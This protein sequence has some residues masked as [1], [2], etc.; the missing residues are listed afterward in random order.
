MNW[1]KKAQGTIRL[2]LDDE[3]DP[4]DI[5][6]QEN[7]GARGDEVWVKT[8]EEAINYLLKGNVGFVS[9]DND[10]GVEKEGRHLANWIEEQAYHKKIPKLEWRVHSKNVAGKQQIIDAMTNADKYWS[11]KEGI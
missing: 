9:F 1:Y 5:N 8:V 2:W 4:K 11:R 6:I 3:R 10:L 7:F